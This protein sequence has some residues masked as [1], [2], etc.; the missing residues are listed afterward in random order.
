[1][2]DNVQEYIHTRLLQASFSVDDIANVNTPWRILSFAHK[3]QT[4]FWLF[5]QLWNNRS[6]QI[7]NF[8]PAWIDPPAPPPSPSPSS[9]QSPA[10]SSTGQV[11]Q[12]TDS[13]EGMP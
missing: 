9:S 3:D 13:E 10:D 11:K 4:V 5:E 1:M 6:D 7:P 12:E 8:Q 2:L